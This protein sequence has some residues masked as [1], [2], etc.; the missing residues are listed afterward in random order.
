MAKD[1]G[2]LY[3]ILEG[4]YSKYNHKKFIPPD[5]LQFV[6]R[7]NSRADMEIAG[8]LA[9]MFAYGAVEQIEKFLTNLL[10]KL[11]EKPASF[12]Q[13]FSK[14]DQKLFENL[15]YRFNTA[16]DIVNLLS[17]LKKTL[18]KFGSLENLFLAGF[19]NSDENIIPAATK[20]IQALNA[21]DSPGLKFLLSDPTNGGTCKRL[22]LFLRWMIRNDE[23]DAGLWKTVDKSKLIAPVDVHIGRLSR[24]LGLHNKKTINLKTALEI[25]AGLREINPADPIKY[26]FALCRIGILEN[27]TGKKNPYCPSCELAEF[28]ILQTS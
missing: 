24:I 3:E 13:N 19:D 7:Y 16:E 20:F 25:T 26:D 2:N 1:I 5:P 27:C 6:Y 23:V 10:G 18:N 4:L 28:C 15:K 9:A 21:G 12:L 11:G 14:N 8:F 17:A 22:F